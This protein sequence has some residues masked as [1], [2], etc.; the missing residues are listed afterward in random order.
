[1]ALCGRPRLSGD[2]AIAIALRCHHD[3]PAVGASRPTGGVIDQRRHGRSS[4]DIARSR[5]AVI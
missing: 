3:L 2:L 5:G 4:P 1:M